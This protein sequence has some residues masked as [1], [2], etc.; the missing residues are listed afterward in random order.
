MKVPTTEE[1]AC[2]VPNRHISLARGSHA[3]MLIRL[4]SQLI[5]PG[6]NTGI[7]SMLDISALPPPNHSTKRMH[8]LSPMLPNRSCQLPFSHLR[9]LRVVALHEVLPRTL[10]FLCLLV[11]LFLT[12]PHTLAS[13]PPQPTEPSTSFLP[14]LTKQSPSAHAETFR[15]YITLSHTHTRYTS[16]VKVFN[17]A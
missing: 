7:K 13:P 2:D 17:P 9:H 11:Y 5:C 1:Q 12:Q 15:A 16:L 8:C 14:Q 6:C 4:S 10:L 3:E